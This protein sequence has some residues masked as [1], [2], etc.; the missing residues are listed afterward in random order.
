MGDRVKLSNRSVRI[1]TMIHKEV[2]MGTYGLVGLEL[3]EFD[4]TIEKLDFMIKNGLSYEDLENDT[5]YP[6]GD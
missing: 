2:G 1:K 4:K 6:S 3:I 5:T